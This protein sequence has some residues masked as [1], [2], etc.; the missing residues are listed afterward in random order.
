MKT[1]FKFSVEG[2][3]ADIKI[4]AF[5]IFTSVIILYLTFLIGRN[6]HLG[7]FFDLIITIVALI[8]YITIMIVLIELLKSIWYLIRILKIEVFKFLLN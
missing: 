8:C 1:K 5:I 2:L 4:Y 7:N 6:T 3:K